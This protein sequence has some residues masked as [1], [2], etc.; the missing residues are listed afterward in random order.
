MND[1]TSLE[2]W[3]ANIDGIAVLRVFPLCLDDEND[4]YEFHEICSKYLELYA[5]DRNEFVLF[6]CRFV[7]SV[8]SV[9]RDSVCG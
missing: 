4:M 6:G 7:S 9:V 8:L 5:D 2:N 1:F 3:N